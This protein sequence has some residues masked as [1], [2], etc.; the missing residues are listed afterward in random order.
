LAVVPIYYL[1]VTVSGIYGKPVT[2][3]EKPRLL[4]PLF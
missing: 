3:G 4:V 2:R 1:F